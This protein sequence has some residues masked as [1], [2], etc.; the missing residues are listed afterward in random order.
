M[1]EDLSANYADAFSNHLEPGDKPALLIVD[2][3][4]AY[5]DPDSPLYAKAEAALESNVRL[6]Q[7]A[8][9]A[10]IPVI[11]TRLDYREDG[12]DGGLF[13]RKLP[14]AIN[15]REGSPLGDFPPGLQPDPQ[16]LVIS[17]QYP[18]AF[19]GTT[20]A[21]TL[22]YKG[23]DTLFIT[24][25]STSGC[26]RATVLDAMQHGFIPMVVRDACADRHPSPHEAN[27]FDMQAKYAEVISESEALALFA[28]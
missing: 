23:I 20:L 11:F 17:K 24:G 21:S 19:F 10:G 26:V 28:R 2:V 12:T 5:L 1:N 3:V 13:L 25:Y 27:L 16:D 8:S 9:A 4:M 18:S 14:A 7:A 22:R 15:C 6:R